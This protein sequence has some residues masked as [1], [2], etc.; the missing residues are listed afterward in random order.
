MEHD[1]GWRFH[2]IRPQVVGDVGVLVRDLVIGAVREA[3][4]ESG[5]VGGER[6]VVVGDIGGWFT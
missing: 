5:H 6:A 2:R 3:K 1:I 4:L